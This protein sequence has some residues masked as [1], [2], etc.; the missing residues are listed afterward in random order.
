MSI[1]RCLQPYEAEIYGSFPLSSTQRASYDFCFY[2]AQFPSPR[3][4]QSFV[5][6]SQPLAATSAL[7]CLLVSPCRSV[8]AVGSLLV[9]F[10]L[11]MSSRSDAAPRELPLT[12]HRP[13]LYS[14]LLRHDPPSPFDTPYS[15]ARQMCDARGSHRL[16]PASSPTFRSSLLSQNQHRCY[17]SSDIFAHMEIKL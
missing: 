7:R 16:I 5:I 15:R 14:R 12:R 17:R 4:T 13:P 3:P 9:A 11:R 6:I 2:P 1:Q 10:K 8:D